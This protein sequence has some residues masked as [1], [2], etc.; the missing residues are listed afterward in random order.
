M[1]VLITNNTLAARAGSELYVRDLAL[2]LLRRGHTPLVYST[3][4]GEVA[5]ELSAATVPVVD[6]LNALGAPPD[7]IHG[8]HHLDMMTA[9]M[10]FD[11]TPAI[12]V[13]HGWIPWEEAPPPCSPR[14]L[15]YIAVDDTCRD[16]LIFQHGI[17]E[18]KVQ[19]FLNFVDLARFRPR[20]PLPANPAK[21][22]LFS[23]YFNDGG[24]VTVFREACAG[25][26]IALDVMGFGSG[27]ACPAPESRL[28][29]YDLVF[30]KGRAALEAMATGNAVITCSH[31]RLG[32]MVTVVG[33]A[34]QRRLNFGVRH[35]R[36]PLDVENIA[37]EIR[38]YSSADAAEVSAWI[39]A[40]A[41]LE[42]AV[43][44]LI[45][46]YRETV[47]EAA[48]Q[49]A[50]DRGA[51][52]RATASYLR[53]LSPTLKGRHGAE[54]RAAQSTIR[55]EALKVELEALQVQLEALKVQ[56]TRMAEDHLQTERRL[57]AQAEQVDLLLGQVADRNAVAARVAALT[58]EITTLSKQAADRD[59]LALRV[60][61]LTQ[62]TAVLAR[63]ASESEQLRARNAEDLAGLQARH[64]QA[65]QK[66][67]ALELL[68]Q[69]MRDE[70][71]CHTHQLDQIASSRTWRWIRRF[72]RFR[73]RWFYAPMAM[74]RRWRARLW[75]GAGSV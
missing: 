33:L 52:A 18:T 59:A 62:E 14:I 9:L 36:H 5:R 24:D 34:E 74:L 69:Q 49:G 39:R 6:D 60:T 29:A 56:N 12:Y 41:S 11:R 61:S 72:G 15:K 20:P 45:S 67:R 40:E 22:L 10:H 44:R 16:R 25:Q 27:N 42:P 53:W 17:P 38:R 51:E 73:E 30:A 21:A 28:G 13:C 66:E 1:R 57:A 37:R 55:L 50:F 23:N 68:L 32:G 63:H 48:A 70:R 47:A 2:A 4:L 19:V 64:E 54:A 75:S 31:V 43:D 26:G 7:I 8:H 58:Q 35:L 3:D 46:M 71:E 65:V